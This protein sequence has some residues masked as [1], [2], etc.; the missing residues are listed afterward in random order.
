MVFVLK[1]LR[2]MRQTM[3][4]HSQRG[5]TLMET[6]IAMSILAVGILGLAAMLGDSLA[7]MKGSQEDFIAQ[8]KAEEAAE[9]IFTAKYNSNATFA[10]VSNF[11]V[12]NPAGLF[13]PGPQ[14][15]TVPGPDG[16]VGSVNDGAAPL[17]SI[18]TPGPD[19][20][21]GTPDDVLVP[22]TNFTRTITITTVV[23]KP[24]LK[25]VLITI[26]YSTGR[27]NRQYTLTT[28]VSSF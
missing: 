18:I 11:A 8:Q 24:N 27:W 25:Q 16:L 7:Y 23:G 2:K 14:A 19:K 4:K 17:A 5:F 9:A 21:L 3:K 20:I 22:L 15:L 12:G 1:E 26:N 28:Y 10:Q 6:L 13:L